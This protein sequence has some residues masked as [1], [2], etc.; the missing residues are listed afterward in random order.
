M[1]WYEI[2]Q[3]HK[4]RLIKA[5]SRLSGEMRTVRQSM[6]DRASRVAAERHNDL[7][8]ELLALA[9]AMTPQQAEALSAE[10]KGYATSLG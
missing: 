7:V 9:V 10:L 3:A 4:D 6:A 5:H 8:D 2:N 1:R